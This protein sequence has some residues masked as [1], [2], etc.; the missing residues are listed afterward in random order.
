ME[1]T[2][3]PVLRKAELSLPS[4][5]IQ[6]STAKHVATIL[7]KAISNEMTVYLSEIQKIE[8]ITIIDIDKEESSRIV[9]EGTISYVVDSPKIT[10]KWG[11][12]LFEIRMTTAVCY[13][14]SST[15]NWCRISIPQGVNHYDKNL[16]SLKLIYDKLAAVCCNI[17]KNIFEDILISESNQSIKTNG[18]FTVI[19]FGV[20]DDQLGAHLDKF[21]DIDLRL[22][23]LFSKD[24]KAKELITKYY[25]SLFNIGDIPLSQD[26]NNFWLT[27]PI[28]TISP[29]GFL[30]DRNAL[31]NIIVSENEVLALGLVHD[32]SE[33]KKLANLSSLNVARIFGK[34]I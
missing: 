8:G 11:S 28:D 3:Y 5:G 16:A 9:P 22:K 26:D 33:D 4:I 34:E 10:A 1:Q 15:K 7:K 2:I 23:D 13:Q 29:E 17:S 27:S 32:T 30:D 24:E 21:D 25:R 6:K 19:T 14:D 18:S 12:Y 31:Y 20:N